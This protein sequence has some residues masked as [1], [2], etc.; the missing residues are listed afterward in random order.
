MRGVFPERDWKFLRKIKPE[1]LNTL[2]RRINQEVV[3]MIHSSEKSEHEK[4]LDV[5]TYIQ[6]I[7]RVVADCFDDWRR[8][9][10]DIKVAFLLRN[11]L[12]TDEHVQKLSEETQNQINFRRSP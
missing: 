12:L 4:Y 5:Y 7:D 8:S 9:N 2:C 11:N 1:M 3:H 10:I 6:K